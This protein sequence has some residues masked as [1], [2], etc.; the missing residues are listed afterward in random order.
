MGRGDKAPCIL[1]VCIRR[2]E[3]ANLH[4]DRNTPLDHRAA[5]VKGEILHRAENRNSAAINDFTGYIT[6]SFKPRTVIVLASLV[7]LIMLRQVQCI[8]EN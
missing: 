7:Y 3:W 6:L 8:Q 2:R 1:N 4:S 5:L